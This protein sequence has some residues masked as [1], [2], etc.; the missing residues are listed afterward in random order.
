[1]QNAIVSIQDSEGEKKRK[2][3]NCDVEDIM[4]EYYILVICEH[5]FI[6]TQEKVTVKLKK[7][8]F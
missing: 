2:Y 6:F 7:S 5:F 3:T 4:D 8:S 1:M